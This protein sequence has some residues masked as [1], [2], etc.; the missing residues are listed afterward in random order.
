MNKSIIYIIVATLF[1]LYSLD[2][3]KTE[4]YMGSYAHRTDLYEKNGKNENLG[5]NKKLGYLNPPTGVI[6][7]NTE[8]ERKAYPY[9]F[10]GK[11]CAS[12]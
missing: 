12:L 8:N 6:R 9:T 7:S 11:N 4:K 3:S 10:C 5:V 2:K 1:I